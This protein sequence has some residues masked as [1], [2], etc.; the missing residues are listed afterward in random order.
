MA[1]SKETQD[2]QTW[3]YENGFFDEGVSRRRAI[4]GYA[5]NMTNAAMQR[6]QA[7]GWTYNNGQ[8]SKAETK[9]PTLISRLFG[10][11]NTAPQDSTYTPWTPTGTQGSIGRRR[12]AKSFDENSGNWVDTEQCA[13]WANAALRQYKDSTGN[14]VYNGNHVTGNAWT[15]LNQGRGTR[16]VYS[17]Y[18]GMDYNPDDA[19]WAQARAD[20]DAWLAAEANKAGSGKVTDAM[21]QVFAASDARNFAAADNF[22]NNFQVDSLDKNKT[23]LVNMYY[24]GS[25]NRATAWFDAKGGTTGT[26]TGNLYWDPQR[27]SWRVAHNIH[28]KV[29]DDDFA[30]AQGSGKSYGITAISEVRRRSDKKGLFGDISRFGYDVGLWKQGGK[31]I[32]RNT[33]N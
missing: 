21:R 10:Q 11:R 16:M 18:S 17:G 15:R 20:N 23:Y 6:A 24:K 14:A 5:G 8:W 29:Y 13:A 33:N 27:N 9:K 25:P 31:L 4:D 30:S 26:H 28:G 22:K 3:L 19:Q 1:Y 32:P 7:A 12:T 2:Q